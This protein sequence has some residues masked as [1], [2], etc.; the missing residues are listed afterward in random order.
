MINKAKEYKVCSKTVMDNIT[1]PDIS[2]DSNGISNHY[3][4][5]HKRIKQHWKNC[6]I[7]EELIEKK[8]KINQ[9]TIKKR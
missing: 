2:F 4:N 1:D 8:N 9:K 6:D 5:F 3:W 7:G